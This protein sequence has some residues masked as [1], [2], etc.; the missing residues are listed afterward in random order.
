VS[1]KERRVDFYKRSGALWRFEGVTE[2]GQIELSC[3][4][5]TLTLDAI[6]QSV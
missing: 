4:A 2:G 1:Q 3:P 5:M 6:Y